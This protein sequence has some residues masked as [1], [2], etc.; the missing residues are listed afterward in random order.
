ME[1]IRHVFPEPESPINNIL[2]L[3][4]EIIV[5]NILVISGQVSFDNFSGG[6]TMTARD[7]STI[8]AVREKRIRSIIMKVKM[9]DVNANFFDK[10]QNVLEPYKYGTCPIKVK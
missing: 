3:F 2:R 10:L 7:V 4:M 1:L 5:F 9:Q 6:I 8:E